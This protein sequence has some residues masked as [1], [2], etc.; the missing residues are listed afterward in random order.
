VPENPP[1]GWVM[2][3]I[4]DT[5]IRVLE[6]YAKELAA[7]AADEEERRANSNNPA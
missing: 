4:Y 1:F 3:L 5:T 6:P 7:I 2:E